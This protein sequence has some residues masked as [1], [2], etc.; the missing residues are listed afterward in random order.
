MCVVSLHACMFG[1]MCVGVC[2]WCVCVVVCVC[3]CMRLC[4]CVVVSMLLCA[5]GFLFVRGSDIIVCHMCV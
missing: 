3:V 1:L 4:V 5:S 2:V